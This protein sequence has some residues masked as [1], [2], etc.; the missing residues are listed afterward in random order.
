M[1]NR[2]VFIL[3]YTLFW[4]IFFLAVKIVFLF[5]NLKLSIAWIKLWPVILVKGILLDFSVIGYILLLPSLLMIFN[6]VFPGRW[7]KL[8]IRTFTYLILVCF[9]FLVISDLVIYPEWGFRLDI[10]P[11]YYLDNP[12]GALAS[13]KGFEII[14]FSFLSL[15]LAFPFYLLFRKLF[16]KSH[17]FEQEKNIWAAPAFIFF[18]GFLF[19]PIRGGLGTAP[20]NTGSVYFHNNAFVNH[21]SLN[22]FWNILYSV[23]NMNDYSNPFNF[24]SDYDKGNIPRV[25][26]END[27]ETVSVLNTSHPNVLVIILESFTANVVG[28]LN[29][30]YDVAQNLDSLAK[31]GI[32]FSNFFASGDRSDKGLISILS[33]FPALPTTSIIKYPNK[34]EKLPG[35]AKTLKKY[36]YKT[37]YYYGGDIDFANM[38]SYIV[39]SGFEK[40]ISNKDFKSK[41]NISSWGVPD[42]FLFQYVRQ[43][44]EKERSPYFKVMFTLS[45]HKPYDVPGNKIWVEGND[46]QNQF[47]NSVGYTDYHLGL[48]INNLKEGGYLENT[49]VII[50]ADHGSAYPGPVA[51][52]SKAKYHIPLVF[53]GPVLQEKEKVIE[54]FGYQVDLPAT[55]LGQLG[56]NSSEYTYSKNL[57]STQPINELYY[58]YNKGFGYIS[59]DIEFI[60]NLPSDKISIIKGVL[61]DSIETNAKLYYQY[62]YDNFL[63]LN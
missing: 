46:D 33:G 40:I 1:K 41:E 11:L 21:A 61:N 13:I 37:A 43:E 16:L 39:N 38:R 30:K 23:T 28:S 47:L 20:I 49:L 29:D 63:E 31:E 17:L 34:T 14:L 12:E 22:L 3:K 48:F 57:L 35:L 52:N 32:L 59:P 8:I 44:I 56:M 51:F 60:Y 36:G 62:L 4:L 15:L 55:I 6:A 10:T 42:E 26:S 54:T 9:S 45:S 50:L 27:K 7:Y 58:T 53:Y 25:N 5:V 2:L 19:L 18:L 24:Y